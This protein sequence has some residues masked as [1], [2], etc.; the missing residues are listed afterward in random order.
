VRCEWLPPSTAA[1][2][3]EAETSR[4]CLDSGRFCPK[5]AR[6]AQHPDRRGRPTYARLVKRID[7]VKQGNEWV[8]KSGGDIVA[9]ATRKEDAVRETAKVAKADSEAVS[10]RIHTED[11]RVQ[12]ERTYPRSAD[13]V[14]SPG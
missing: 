11:G 8:A 6:K 13:P 3:S 14:R 1:H 7:I 10:V 2:P 9:R 5:C 12:E 4:I